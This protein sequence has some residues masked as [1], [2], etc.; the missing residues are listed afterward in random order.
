MI[1][2]CLGL[3]LPYGYLHRTVISL[4][5]KCWQSYFQPGKAFICQDQQSK[6]HTGGELGKLTHTPLVL[7]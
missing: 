4:L 7:I 5:F 3:R 2:W 1:V 6:M